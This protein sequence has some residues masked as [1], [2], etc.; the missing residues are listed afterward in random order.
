MPSRLANASRY[1]GH[2]PYA[3]PSHALSVTTRSVGTSF[4]T[5]DARQKDMVISAK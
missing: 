3:S 2:V 4:F 1:A 5:G